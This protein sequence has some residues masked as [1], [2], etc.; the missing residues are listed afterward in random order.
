MY[1]I[2]FFPYKNSIS[3]IILFLYLIL[4]VSCGVKELYIRGARKIGVIGVPPIGCVPSQRTLEGGLER[5][6]SE[7]ENQAALL[8]NSKLSSQMDAL[9][10]QLPGCRLVYLDIYSTLLDIIKNPS[11][12]GKHTHVCICIFGTLYVIST[13]C[14]CGRPSMLSIKLD[15]KLPPVKKIRQSDYTRYK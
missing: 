15:C 5:Q 14:P 13:P 3:S 8:F 4:W 2:V 6:C 1:S 7:L 9:N 11:K 10:S 12:Y